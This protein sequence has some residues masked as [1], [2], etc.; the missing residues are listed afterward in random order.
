MFESFAADD[1]VLHS[2]LF[3][4]EEIRHNLLHRI[5][6]YA[7]AKNPVSNKVYK[8]IGFIEAG[9]IADIKFN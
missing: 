7:D 8:S 3:I 2:E 6:E 1:R 9:Q 5:I 4:E